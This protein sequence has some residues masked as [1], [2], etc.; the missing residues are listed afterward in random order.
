MGTLLLLLGLAAADPN[1]SGASIEARR[2]QAVVWQKKADQLFSQGK[3]G[4]ALEAAQ[5]SYELFPTAR[6]AY[7]V[8]LIQIQLGQRESAFEQCVAALNLGPTASDLPLIEVTLAELGPQ[9]IPPRG[10]LHVVTEPAP[11]EVTVVASSAGP[12]PSPHSFGAAV[13]A[14]R[15][16]LRLPG[17]QTVERDV[18]VKAGEGIKLLVQLSLEPAAASAP[19]AARGLVESPPALVAANALSVAPRT[20]PA[21]TTAA[22]AAPEKRGRPMLWTGIGL[23]GG[24]VLLTATL[25]IAWGVVDVTLGSLT[26]ASWNGRQWVGWSAVGLG[27]ATALSS[28]VAVSG[29]AVSGLA[30]LTGE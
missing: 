29:V 18:E 30:L 20:D 19:A 11:V 6:T 8:A 21:A 23:L 28:L 25:G 24:G 7:N 12:Q 16:R 3:Y 4:P 13:G 9:L 14:Q 26:H 10:W 27:A 1:A 2:A 17:Y 15:V 22:T 5:R